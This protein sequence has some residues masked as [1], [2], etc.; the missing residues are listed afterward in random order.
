[1]K[2]III[3]FLIIN[4]LQSFVYAIGPDI[5]VQS[6]VNRASSILSKNISKEEKK[7]A[8]NDTLKEEHR[9]PLAGQCSLI[10]TCH[11][12]N[13]TIHIEGEG[14]GTK[15]TLPLYTS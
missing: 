8:Q 1:M 7:A 5:F 2:K 15:S 11:S 6:T 14:F 12:K 9:N 3:T 10:I 13:Q 4:L